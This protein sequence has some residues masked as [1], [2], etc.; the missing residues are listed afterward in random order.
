MA[1]ADVVPLLGSFRAPG[2][3]AGRPDGSWSSP[4]ARPTGRRSPFRRRAAKPAAFHEAE[5]PSTVCSGSRRSRITPRG[6][7]AGLPLT[8]PAPSGDER[9][10]W[11]LQALHRSERVGGASRGRAPFVPAGSRLTLDESS[12]PDE[13]GTVASWPLHRSRADRSAPT[14]STINVAR[15]SCSANFVRAYMPKPRRRRNRKIA[16]HIKYFLH[17]LIHRL[18]RRAPVRQCC[19]VI[20]MA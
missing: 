17:R 6:C 16:C 1:M 15:G 3:P 7:S 18:S 11:A 14:A 5:V 4:W 2:S 9:L 13:L 19:R 20:S 12:E 10:G 8:P